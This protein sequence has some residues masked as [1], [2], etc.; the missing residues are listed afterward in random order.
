MRIETEQS[1]CK[2]QARLALVVIKLGS[3]ASPLFP[4]SFAKLNSSA[5]YTTLPVL[6]TKVEQVVFLPQLKKGVSSSA[7]KKAKFRAGK[8]G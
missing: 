7:Q 4:S 5:D 8:A 3:Q 2:F 1:G 6:P